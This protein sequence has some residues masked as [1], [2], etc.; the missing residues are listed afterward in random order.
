MRTIKLFF[1]LAGFVA[2][3]HAHAQWWTTG[4]VITPTD[5]IGATLGTNT[6][7]IVFKTGT[8]STLTERFRINGG[9][10]GRVG[11]NTPSPQLQLHVTSSEIN[12]GIR[13]TQAGTGTFPTIMGGFANLE[14]ENLTTQVVS[15]TT[16]SGHRYSVASVGVSNGYQLAGGFAIYDHTT[17][18][19]RFM[20]SST[21]KIGVGLGA[22]N[23][24]HKFHV[25]DGAIKVT[26]SVS[27][28]GG[29]MILFGSANA[30]GTGTEKWG[31]EYTTVGEPG[32]NFWRP[33][34]G[35]NYLFLHDNGNVGIG[36][37]DPGTFKLAVE[38]KL[39]AR[40][41]QVLLT[42]PWPDYVFEKGYDLKPLEEVK[43][44]VEENKHLPNVPSSEDL[45][46]N[47]GVELGNMQTLQMEKIENIYL[48]L[49]EM[50]ERIKHLEA[51]N[52]QLKKELSNNETEK[53]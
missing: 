22:I 8:G 10:V 40:E 29:P 6:N 7:P 42:N 19:Y 1:A 4:N 28:Y 46:N 5:Y 2:A 39:G 12:G 21:G 33:T 37:N 47:N 26:G 52:A 34:I 44:F 38:G 17:S 11:I 30:N 13:V 27:G 31:I 16:Y 41:V 32:L 18:A 25:H 53:K 9:T 49:F 15:G 51:E 3:G 43:S 35:N 48:Y 36:T 23:A 50:N 20:I 24:D 14:L 45:I